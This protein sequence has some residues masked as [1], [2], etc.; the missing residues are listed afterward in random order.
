MSSVLAG[1]CAFVE[2]HHHLS[3]SLEWIAASHVWMMC[4]WRCIVQILRDQSGVCR[5]L[6]GRLVPMLGTWHIIKQGHA[7]VWHMGSKAF[8]QPYFASLIP[9]AK[10]FNKGIKLRT[11]MTYFAF[12]RL[13]Y[14]HFRAQL[15]AAIQN[16]HVAAAQKVH[17]RNLQTLIEVFM[18]IVSS[19]N[20]TA[21]VLVVLH[22][23]GGVHDLHRARSFAIILLQS[24]CSSL[25]SL[26]LVCP[27]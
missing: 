1:A 3:M 12:I 26:S 19:V 27:R 6:E 17:L 10:F 22:V 5:A 23:I 8:F 15:Q 20:V 4:V 9:G 18:P 24:G 16:V 25:V 14:P 7:V 21:W 13:A 2:P 11:Q